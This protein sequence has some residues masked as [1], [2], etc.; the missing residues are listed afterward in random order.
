MFLDDGLSVEYN[1]SFYDKE[2]ADNIF[3]ELKD[4]PFFAPTLSIRGQNFRPYRKICAFSDPG[5]SY[6]FSGIEVFGRQWTPLLQKLKNDVERAIGCEYNFV[7]VN[8]YPDGRSKI[9]DHKDNESS[10]HPNVPIAAL[11]FGAER[12]IHFKRPG[13]SIKTNILLKH[14]SMYAMHKPTN[15]LFTHGIPA[16]INVKSSRISLTFRKLVPEP[17]DGTALEEPVEPSEPP[18]KKLKL[19]L[20]EVEEIQHKDLLL[21]QWSIDSESYISLNLI[22]DKLRVRIQ[23]YRMNDEGNEVPTF[24]EVTMTVDTF[25]ELVHKLEDVNF[26]YKDASTIAN[27]QLAIIV[28]DRQVILQQIFRKGESFTMWSK[29]VKLHPHQV[30]KLKDQRDQIMQE[31]QTILLCRDLPHMILKMKPETCSAS[32]HYDEDTAKQQYFNAI[33][34]ELCRKINI[35]YH[36]HGCI[37]D[38]LSQRQH[39]CLMDSYKKKFDAVGERVFLHLNLKDISTDIIGHFCNCCY[40]NEFFTNISLECILNNLNDLLECE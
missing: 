27:N 15:R 4:L 23:D 10:L 5:L 25:S 33:F 18:M 11:S 9:S 17:Y 30:R 19:E 7:L 26:I 8:L 36:C 2:D 21:V 32:E 29:H 1:S 20:N 39:G 28:E 16:E 13:S 3:N 22:R 12:T 34:K 14:G 37:T 35:L 6:K 38:H 24:S 40:H 31:I